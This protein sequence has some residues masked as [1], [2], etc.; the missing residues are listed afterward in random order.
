MSPTPDYFGYAFAAIVILGGF[1]GFARKGSVPS[2]LM[3]ALVGLCLL[4]AASLVSQNP[5]NAGLG[6][7]TCGVLSVVMGYR[8]FL[9]GAFMPAGLVAGLGVAMSGRYALKLYQ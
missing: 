7:V 3:G 1:I 2:L 5:K 6:F 8:F 9:S 4:Y